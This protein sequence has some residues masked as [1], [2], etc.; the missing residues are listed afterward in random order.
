[1][2]CLRYNLVKADFPEIHAFYSLDSYKGERAWE[3]VLFLT[4]RFPRSCVI[5]LR[6]TA[7]MP[8]EEVME[9]EMP[10]GQVILYR[11]PVLK[12]RNYS[13][14]EIFEKNLLILLP[15]YIINYEKK[16]SVIAKDEVRI[17]MLI[18]EYREIVECLAEATKKDESGTFQDILQM[19]RELVRYLLR[20]QPELRERMGDVMGGK[21][22]PLPSDKLREEREAGLQQGISQTISA[23]IETCKEFNETKEDTVQRLVKKFSMSSEDAL[24]LVEEH[25]H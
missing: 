9:I 5:Y 12:L 4:I 21:V 20:K 1:M 14:D 15:Y 18:Q 3:A 16:I 10:D 17:R 23:V 11:V 2:R 8:D 24:A 25:W 6:T 7:T 13:I 19:M 22:L